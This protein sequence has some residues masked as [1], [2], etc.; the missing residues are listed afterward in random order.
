MGKNFKWMWF[1]SDEARVTIVIHPDGLK[2]SAD[3]LAEVFKRGMG[4]HK[5]PTTVFVMDDE[6]SVR[7]SMVFVHQ[8]I[9]DGAGFCLSE[10]A[11]PWLASSLG[12][13]LR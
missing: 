11:R 13:L 8:I 2:M 12:S 6:R 10:T 3:D 7:G 1:D 4:R 5:K 9:V